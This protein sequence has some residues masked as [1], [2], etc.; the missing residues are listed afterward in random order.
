M[1]YMV[2]LKNPHIIFL[3]DILEMPCS[4]QHGLQSWRSISIRKWFNLEEFVIGFGLISQQ[5]LKMNWQV[6]INE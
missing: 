1:N 5:N 4:R 3:V 6:V 2:L